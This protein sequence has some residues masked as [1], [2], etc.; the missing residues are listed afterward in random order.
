VNKKPETL[1]RLRTEVV[2]ILPAE[3]NVSPKFLLTFPSNNPSCAI[4][5]CIYQHY[6]FFISLESNFLS[7]YGGKRHCAVL[8]VHE[9]Y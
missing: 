8:C 2:A 1:K 6:N 7:N 3:N 4:L 5:S 9:T